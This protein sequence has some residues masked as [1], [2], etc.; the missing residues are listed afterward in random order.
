MGAILPPGM[1]TRGVALVTRNPD[2]ANR[3]LELEPFH[4]PAT[5]V[6]TANEGRGLR[7]TRNTKRCRIPLDRTAEPQGNI[8]EKNCL[9][10]RPRITE[11]TGRCSLAATGIRPLHVVIG[12]WLAFDDMTPEVLFRP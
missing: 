9:G 12:R 3:I 4:F 1:G 6:F 8:P 2:A 11:R 7:V 5:P 10:Q